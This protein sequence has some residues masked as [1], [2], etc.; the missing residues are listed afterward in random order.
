MNPNSEKHN[1]INDIF[2]FTFVDIFWVTLAT[3]G[4]SYHTSVLYFISVYR[5]Q[6]RFMF[7]CNDLSL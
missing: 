6:L 7:Y 3:M 4:K 2:D 5:A 1:Q